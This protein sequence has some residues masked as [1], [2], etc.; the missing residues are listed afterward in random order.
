VDSS[1]N[2]YVVGTTQS[3]NF[4]TLNAF[5]PSAGSFQDAFIAKL[6]STGS[7][8]VYSTYF[9][10]NNN[11]FGNGIA[12]DSSGN[13]YVTGAT[14][15]TNFPVQNPIQAS[16][17]SLEDAFIAELTSD[18]S[19]LVY[20]TYLGGDARDF[21]NSIA[22]DT[23]G[24]AYITG[25]TGSNDFPTEDAFQPNRSSFRDA[26]VVKVNQT[27]E[28]LLYSTY[29]GGSLDDLG[30]GITV[31]RAGNAYIVGTTESV[32]FPTPGSP[33][34][35]SNAGQ[36]DVFVSKL[37]PFGDTFIYSTYLGGSGDDFGNG[38][39]VDSSGNAY[40]T[41]TTQS[42]DFP[43]ANA[44]DNSLGGAQDAF[45]TKLNSTGTAPLVYSTY[46]G[47]SGN[48][49]GNGI[50]VD[51]SGNAYVTGT[52]QSGDFPR[53]N[54]FDNSLGGAQD[55]FVTKFDPSLSGVPSLIYSTYL[56][57]N[58]DD[59]GNGVA[60]DS[61]NNAYVVGTTQSNDFPFTAGAF[62]TANAGSN[63]AFVT[64]FNSAGSV[65]TYSTYLG[66]SMDDLGSG[67]ALDTS[68]NAYV[69]GSTV[70]DNFP[71]KDPLQPFLEGNSDAFITKLNSTGTA[72]LVYSTY[73]G[74]VNNDLG[75]GIAVDISGNAYVTGTTESANFPIANAFQANLLGTKDSF[76]T[77]VNAAGDTLV[78][79]SYLGGT[80]DDLGN[81]IAVDGLGNAF[82][83]GTTDSTNFPT[84]SVQDNPGGGNDGFVAKVQE[85]EVTDS[86]TGGGNEATGGGGGA[87]CFIA[88]AANGS[89]MARK[90]Q[91]LSA[92]FILLALL[93][94]TLFV[95]FR[96]LKLREV[97]FKTAG[98][99]SK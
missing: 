69:V 93:C 13:A 5:Q 70:S 84:K 87:S 44:F 57:G 74:G 41:G 38:I 89:S 30:N 82:V 53:A 1:N 17:A 81:A 98:L 79:S 75:N 20:S 2:A 34:Q 28:A 40:V 33:F 59:F 80:N 8:L 96:R 50:A 21:G 35:G 62:Q 22:V 91:P 26:F 67:I 18:G 23:S 60:L 24:N 4:P 12:L 16:S 51:S 10:G 47:G 7:A 66:G 55:A 88:T 19:T 6:D 42:G 64:K 58:N 27:G 49:F 36:K 92:I 61:S 29:L 85:A 78:Y 52:T 90:L 37:D 94:T 72:P 65:L 56:G 63:D 95:L 45:V 97:V 83:A 77:K 73:L 25:T 11:D 71:V 32:N 15:S 46:L 31:D 14:L 76:V 48:D 54:A 43:R 99:K 3:T 68:G 86:S 39:A 9:G